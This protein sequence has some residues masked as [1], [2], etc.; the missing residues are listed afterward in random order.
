[1][2][3][4]ADAAWRKRFPDTVRCLL[5]G[6]RLILLFV[7]WYFENF[8]YEVWQWKGS[9]LGRCSTFLWIQTMKLSRETVRHVAMLA[10][11]ELTA[12]EED[13]YAEQLGSILG[14]FGRLQE[15]DT[16]R[17]APT[18]HVLEITNVLREDERRESYPTEE[19]LRNAPDSSGSFFRVPRI[20]D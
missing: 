9:Q 10:R 7:P 14:F 17:V 8:Q 1:M 15:V 16:S 3:A 18:S 6:L 20:L 4:R 19:I 11:I 2:E 5:V 12:E 13:L